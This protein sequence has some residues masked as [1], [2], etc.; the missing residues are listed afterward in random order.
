MSSPLATQRIQSRL[1]IQSVNCPD[2]HSAAQFPLWFDMQQFKNLLVQLH[3]AV[4]GSS[5]G[6]TLFE[7]WASD[8]SDGST[9][10]TQIKAKATV[11]DAGVNAV[12]DQLYLECSA[13]EIN[14]I[15]RLISSVANGT[16][17]NPNGVALRY[18]SA[19]ITTVAAGDVVVVNHVGYDTL[20]P[21]DGLTA[22]A[23]A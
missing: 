1:K 4:K 17:S 8:A 22:D 5:G 3:F 6:I 2:A 11:N 9:N 19:K 12:N 7:L 23:I 16:G 10:K 14:A 18:V 13:D 21:R 20:W 15:G